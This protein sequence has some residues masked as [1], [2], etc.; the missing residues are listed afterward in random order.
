[1]LD[2]VTQLLA[3]PLPPTRSMP[4]GVSPPADAQSLGTPERAQES[5]HVVSGMYDKAEASVVELLVLDQYVDQVLTSLK[6]VP[7]TATL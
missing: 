3:P 4:A 6:S 7:P 5:F 2:D 1:V